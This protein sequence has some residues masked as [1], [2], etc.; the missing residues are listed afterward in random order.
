MTLPTLLG[1]GSLCSRMMRAHLPLRLTL[2]CGTE[3]TRQVSLH[4]VHLRGQ[5]SLFCVLRKGLMYAR[6]ASVMLGI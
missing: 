1:S 6:L 5:H 2:G 4:L 3:G